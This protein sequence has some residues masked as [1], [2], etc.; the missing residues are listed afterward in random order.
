MHPEWTARDIVNADLKAQG[1][2]HR[3]PPDPYTFVKMSGYKGKKPKNRDVKSLLYY[4]NI[5][6]EFED[7]PFKRKYLLPHEKPK[8]VAS[9]NQSA[10]SYVNGQIISNIL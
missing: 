5:N 4:R 8:D 6:T 9:M 1:F 10:Y 3:L 2:K 7:D